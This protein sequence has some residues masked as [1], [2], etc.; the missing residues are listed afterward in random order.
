MTCRLPD[1]GRLYT[2]CTCHGKVLPLV[3]GSEL[4]T[5]VYLQDVMCALHVAP[6][7]T[8]GLRRRP[9]VAERLGRSVDQLA[10]CDQLVGSAV[11]PHTLCWAPYSILRLRAL[12]CHV[13]TDLC[14]LSLALRKPTDSQHRRRA[15]PAPSCQ[16]C[17]KY[18]G[19][20]S[21]ASACSCVGA[22]P[23]HSTVT[24]SEAR[25]DPCI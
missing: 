14:I 16:S 11:L 22:H 1:F 7:R 20:L 9:C 12:L 13:W 24:S 3:H 8:P 21:A 10:L 2:C 23:A 4:R 18:L 15:Q 17:R 19:P 5:A 25:R 6:F